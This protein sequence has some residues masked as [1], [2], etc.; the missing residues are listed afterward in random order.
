MAGMLQFTAG[1]TTPYCLINTAVSISSIRYGD[2]IVVVLTV[3]S[4]SMGIS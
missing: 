1:P 3:N 2:Y 4:L